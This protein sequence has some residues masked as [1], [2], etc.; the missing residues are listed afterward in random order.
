[1]EVQS[2]GNDQNYP[3]LFGNERS[4]EQMNLMHLL[5]TGGMSLGLFFIYLTPMPQFLLFLVG[6]FSMGTTQEKFFKI[7]SS[8]FSMWGIQQ[9]FFYAH[10]QEFNSTYISGLANTIFFPVFLTFFLIE[11]EFIQFEDYGK[12]F[13]EE[14]Y[15]LTLRQGI[16][17]HYFGKNNAPTVA[18]V[19][20]QALEDL[21]QVPFGVLLILYIPL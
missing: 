6:E 17:Y 13:A 21:A 19:L 9:A 3:E 4:Y 14:Q 20:I 15:T 2:F 18:D 11:H 5:L 16:M 1:M 10:L 8:T 7:F 12:I